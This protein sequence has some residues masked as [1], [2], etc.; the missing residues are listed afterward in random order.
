MKELVTRSYIFGSCHHG[1][2]VK[3]Y[4]SPTKSITVWAC[5]YVTLLVLT[6]VNI[7]IIADSFSCVPPPINLC[8]SIRKFPSFVINHF[9]VH[10]FST[11][12]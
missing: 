2:V 11:R 5:Y 6:E 8:S 3:S 1:K 7:I 10:L 9:T 4:F 12:R